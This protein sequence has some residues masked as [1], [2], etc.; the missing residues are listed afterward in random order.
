MKLDYC[1]HCGL[2]VFFENTRCVSC[3]H[4]LAFFPDRMEVCSLDE[5]ADGLWRRADTDAGSPSYRLCANYRD[6]NVCNWV[7]PAN[8]P[9][10]QCV[11]CRLTR[12]IPDLAKAGAQEAWCRLETAKRR[13]VYSLLSLKLPLLS[14]LEDPGGGLAFEFRADPDADDKE[15]APVLTGHDHGVIVI[16]KLRFVHSAIGQFALQAETCDAA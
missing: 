10:P 11:S 16:E 7:V 15:S 4:A 14:K 13:L 3:D 1:N 8:D 12:V 2:P 5:A 9:N 6:H